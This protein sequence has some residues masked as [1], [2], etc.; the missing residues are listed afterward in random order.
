MAK[1][2]VAF[3]KFANPPTKCSFVWKNA[4]EGGVEN[5]LWFLNTLFYKRRKL[6]ACPS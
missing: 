2:I 1:I 3:R 4:Y 6:V 5:L